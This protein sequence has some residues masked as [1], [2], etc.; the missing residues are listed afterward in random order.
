MTE[1][2]LLKADAATIVLTKFDGDKIKIA[3]QSIP[4]DQD[5]VLDGQH[6]DIRMCEGM[7]VVTRRD[8]IV[9]M[10]DDEL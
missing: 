5:V 9:P 8:Q 4:G 10:I 7:I 2:I 6:L 3:S 1:K